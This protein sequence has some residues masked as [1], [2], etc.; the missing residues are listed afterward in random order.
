[1]NV[2]LR[3]VAFRKRGLK[4]YATYIIIKWTGLERIPF[5]WFAQ[6]KV[7]QLAKL[8]R[9]REL[10]NVVLYLTVWRSE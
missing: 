5:A 8:S 10:V 9:L 1:M 3:I 4:Q 7:G 6:F 2:W